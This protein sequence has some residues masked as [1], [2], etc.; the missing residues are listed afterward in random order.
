M[1]KQ[2]PKTDIVKRHS[3]QRNARIPMLAA[4]QAVLDGAPCDRRRLLLKHVAGPQ[5]GPE[6]IVGVNSKSPYGNAENLVTQISIQELS[7]EIDQT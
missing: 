3:R 4:P 2:A 6:G 5:V 7:H 1:G